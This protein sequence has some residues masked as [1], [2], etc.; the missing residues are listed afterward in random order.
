MMQ[1]EYAVRARYDMF[2]TLNLTHHAMFDRYGVFLR[3]YCE[4]DL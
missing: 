2:R 1:T 4:I 3:L